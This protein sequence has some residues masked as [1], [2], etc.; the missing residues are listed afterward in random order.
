MLPLCSNA[1][2][3]D[4]LT[5]KYDLLK[6]FIERDHVSSNQSLNSES[7]GGAINAL[8]STSEADEFHV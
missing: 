5:I 7:V 4:Y 6:Q 2:S 1:T 3:S 8:L